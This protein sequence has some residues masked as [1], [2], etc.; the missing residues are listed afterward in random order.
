M[1]TMNT[2]FFTAMLSLLAAGATTLLAQ[3]AV[4]STAADNAAPSQSA[5][6][7]STNQGPALAFQLK[8]TAIAP[9]GAKGTV[10]VKL[11]AISI[12]LSALGQGRYVVRAIRKSD[13]GAEKIGDINIIDPTLSPSAQANDNK[14][15]ASA[16]PDDVS[17]ETDSTMTLPS[18]LAYHDIARVQVL[19]R[20]GNAVLDSEVK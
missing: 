1:R 18:D 6:A 4:R 9:A 10:E 2:R 13:G 17:I 3:G 15:E 7:G 19:A 5:E 11:G 8:P 12:H 14:K 20:G 16:N